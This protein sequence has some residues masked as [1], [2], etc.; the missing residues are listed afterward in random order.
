MRSP[1]P[2][3]AFVYDRCCTSDTTELERRLKACGEYVVAQG[4]GFGGWW[5]DTGDQALVNDHRPAFDTLLRT[6]RAAEGCQRVCLV[7]DWHR[8]SHDLGKRT[9]LVRRLLGL[10]A[11]VETCFGER[12]TPDGRHEPLGSLSGM[13]LT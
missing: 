2:T 5:R 11:T 6:M 3:L 10:G 7:Y 9:I 8:L 1:Q 12:M 4:W 13:P